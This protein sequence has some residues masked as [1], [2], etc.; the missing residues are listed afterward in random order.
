MNCDLKILNWLLQGP[1][2]YNKVGREIDSELLKESFLPQYKVIYEKIFDY[3]SKYKTPPS[4]EVLSQFAEDEM[5]DYLINEIK[6]TNCEESEISFYLD[7]IKERFNVYLAKKL[8]EFDQEESID[9]FN[10]KLVKTAA[11]IDR[12]RKSSVFAE[13]NLTDSVLERLNNYDYI[14]ANPDLAS[15]VKSGFKDIDDYTNGIKKSELMLIVGAS[16]GGKSLLMMNYAVNAWLGSNVPSDPSKWKFD[17]GVNV[18]YFT[19]EM[20][21]SQMEQRIDACMAEIRHFGLTRGS[22]TN[23]EKEKW[24]S[25]LSFQKQYNKHFYIVDMPR[26]SRMLDIEA[27]YETI[28]AEFQPDLVVIDYLGIMSPNHS[29]GSDWQDLGQVAAELH[30]FCRNKNIAV[31]SAA[32]KKAKDK[33]SKDK[34]NDLEDVGRSL[35]IAQN[36]NI[37]LLIESR[38]DEALKSDAIIHVVK[39]RDGARGPVRLYKNFEKSKFTSITDNWINSN[40]D[41]ENSIG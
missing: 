5:Q 18:L 34:S 22:L 30:E 33:K 29:S 37:M 24:V 15:G 38:E 21:K 40:N 39:N 20:S 9:D 12:L 16:S 26:G 19:L 6:E 2:S 28:R 35:M 13:G 25:S 10:Q 31:L 17:N 8:S 4:Y 11:K 41:D 32:Q 23:E 7:K 36:C 3:F 14:V 1:V 27:R